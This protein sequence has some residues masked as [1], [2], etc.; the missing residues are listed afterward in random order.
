MHEFIGRRVVRVERGLN[1]L[2][3]HIPARI[4]ELKRR[5]ISWL[6]A[7]YNRVIVLI[8]AVGGSFGAVLAPFIRFPLQLRAVRSQERIDSFSATVKGLET[9]LISKDEEIKR[10][11]DGERSHDADREHWYRTRQQLVLRIEELQARENP[12]PENPKG[13]EVVIICEDDSAAGRLVRRILDRLGLEGFV[14]TRGYDALRYLRTGQFRLMILDFGLPDD[15][16]G[17][18][19]AIMARREGIDIPREPSQPSFELQR[20]L[21]LP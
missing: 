5:G 16:N 4:G 10:L 14:V 17:I 1:Q 8:A 21:A 18:D 13:S 15:I 12:R 11:Q 6:A 19:V 20:V 9:L 7:D 2:P 3:K